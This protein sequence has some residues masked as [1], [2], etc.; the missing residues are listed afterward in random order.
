MSLVNV[1]KY[2]RISPFDMSTEQGRSDERY[3]R[4]VLSVS[5]NVL[6]RAMGMTL[7]LVSV[8][9]T[10]PYLGA[11]RF[12]IWMVIASIVGLLSFLDFGVGN[13]LSNR[14]SHAAAGGS[15]FRLRRVVSG[16]LMFLFGLGV[17]ISCSLYL[18]SILFPWREFIKTVEPIDAL[19]ISRALST[20]SVLFGVSTFVGGVHRVF[21]GLQRS[22]QAHLM[23][24]LFSIVSLILVLVAAKYQAGIPVLI[25]VTLGVQTLSGIA[26]SFILVIERTFV[27]KG[28]LKNAL[29]QRHDLMKVGGLFLVLQIGTVVAA[30]ADNVLIMFTHGAGQVAV[31]SIAQRLFQFVSQPL[32]VMNAPL[33]AAYAD[34]H[35]R[36]E[37]IFILKTLKRSMA[38]TAI[39]SLLGGAVIFAF[40]GIATRWWTGGGVTLP[41][42]LAF[43][44]FLSTVC[45]SVGGALAM[46]LNGCGIVRE[47]VVTVIILSVSALAIKFLVLNHWGVTEMLASYVALYCFVVILMYGVIYRKK[48]AASL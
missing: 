30:G 21:A 46:M 26:L 4:A 35:A 10:I 40:S 11:E 1:R 22:Y 3:R 43:M 33:W 20:L 8:K 34:A 12:G 39:L 38:I 41:I 23:S 6:S 9:V 27:L 45:E 5:A 37:K 13:A 24:L 17:L 32:G 25:A 36:G 19:E 18:L 14:V 2:F 42:D 44:F 47:Q 28:A 16:G 48:L 15:L 31:F 7:M 29:V